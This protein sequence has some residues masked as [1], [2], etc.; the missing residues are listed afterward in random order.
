ML[1][2]VSVYLQTNH[3]KPEILTGCLMGEDVDGDNIEKLCLEEM[4]LGT[5]EWVCPW[6]RAHVLFSV[7]NRENL[8]VHSVLTS[9]G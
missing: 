2:V 8:Y 3:H 4:Q 5:S 6:R 9:T 7:A 1:Y